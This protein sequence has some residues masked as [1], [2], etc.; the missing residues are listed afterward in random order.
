M[1]L[2]TNGFVKNTFKKEDVK[3]LEE[4]QIMVIFYAVLSQ[5][6]DSL[7]KIHCYDWEYF[8]IV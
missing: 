7:E 1:V 3:Y 8:D 2:L 4:K 5:G 6:N